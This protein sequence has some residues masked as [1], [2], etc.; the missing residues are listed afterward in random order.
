MITDALL[1]LF[2]LVCGRY[3]GHVWAPGG[4]ELPCC[5]RCTGLYV[6]AFCALVLQALYRPPARAGYVWAHLALLAQLVPCAMYWVP[7]GP[8]SRTL[9]GAAFASA[10]VAFL[11]LLPQEAWPAWLRPKER[12]NAGYWL[13]LAASLAGMLALALGGGRP[14]AVVLSVL[15]AAGACSLAAL[16]LLN[17]ACLAR[18]SW[19]RVFAAHAPHPGAPPSP[20]K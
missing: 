9:S 14:G 19:A 6:G 8:I 5:Q 4:F 10:L 16:A 15:T 3:P 11:R 18:W 13:G 20:T 7:Q 2:S 1:D 12:G 17:L